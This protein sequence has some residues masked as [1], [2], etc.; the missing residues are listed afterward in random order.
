[1]G[2]LAKRPLLTASAVFLAASLCGICLDAHLRLIG[3]LV[4][5]IGILPAIAGMLCFAKL[6]REE[7]AQ[8]QFELKQAKRKAKHR[9][10]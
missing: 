4:L 7:Y 1:M 8:R 2:I 5:G 9:G 6:R 10:R 3:M